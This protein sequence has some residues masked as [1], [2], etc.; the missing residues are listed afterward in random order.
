VLPGGTRSGKD[1]AKGG[2]RVVNCTVRVEDPTLTSFTGRV[3]GSPSTQR[4]GKT[5]RGVP[6]VELPSRSS[7]WSEDETATTRSERQ[8]EATTMRRSRRLTGI[9]KTTLA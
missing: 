7:K 8:A 4:G 1:A 6:V 9:L 5:R 2:A 3:T